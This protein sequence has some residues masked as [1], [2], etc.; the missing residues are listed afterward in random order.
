V[1]WPNDPE[2]LVVWV[3]GALVALAAG[4][5]VL[6]WPKRRTGKHAGPRRGLLP[7]V[8]TGA[9]RGVAKVS[10]NSRR[11]PGQPSSPSELAQTQVWGGERRG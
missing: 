7:A 1:N 6:L 2:V 4:L 9:V 5:L 10:V 8:G 3:L 11:Y